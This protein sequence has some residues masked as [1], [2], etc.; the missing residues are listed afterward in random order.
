MSAELFGERAVQSKVGLLLDRVVHPAA[1]D[2]GRVARERSKSVSVGLLLE[3]FC[4]P[5]PRWPA[6]LFVNVQP[7]SVGLL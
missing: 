2:V 7:V 1:A 5:P 3:E 6:E 4:M